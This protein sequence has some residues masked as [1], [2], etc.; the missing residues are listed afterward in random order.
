VSERQ[1][2]VVAARTAIVHDWFQGYHGAERVVDT[3]HSA[4]FA[5]SNRPDIFTFHAAHELL[6]QPLSEAIVKE[7]RLASLPG[8]RQRGHD[9]GRW[10]YLLP[11]MPSYFRNLQLDEYDLVI[12]SSHACAVNARAGADKVHVCYCHTPMRYAWMPLGE[13]ARARGLSR[14]GLR[15]ITIWLRRVDLEASRAPNSYVAN[16][17][18]VRERIERFYGREA[19]VIHPPVDLREFDPGRKKEPGSF[20][21][22]HRLVPYKRP[23]LVA[24]AFHGLPYRLIMVGVGPL[25]RELRKSLPPNVSLRGWVS[26]AE[27]S[28]LFATASGFI[29]VGEE[30]FGITMVEALASGMPVIALDRGGARDIVR[31]ER[32][33]VLIS[34]PTVVELRRAINEVAD[35]RWDSHL[36]AERAA[37]FSQEAFVLRFRA[38]LAELGICLT[39][40]E[41]ASAPSG[42]S[43]HLAPVD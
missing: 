19:T 12:S 6:P 1:S 41:S 31:H 8:V 27:L 13:G 40:G 36:L 17:H 2:L 37:E 33:G 15:A 24:A 25:E 7:S 26:R 43:G 35:A 34:S 20:L 11:L 30:D 29:H 14:A 9:P 4:L 18:A 32:E 3:L 28:D 42:Q 21:W 10:R 16:S 5:S 22:V 38:H 39:A 23:L